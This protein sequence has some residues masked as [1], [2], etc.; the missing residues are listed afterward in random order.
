MESIEA[1]QMKGPGILVVSLE[2]ALDRGDQ[3][4]A[5]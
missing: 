4:G 2:V 5:L 3:V 1:V